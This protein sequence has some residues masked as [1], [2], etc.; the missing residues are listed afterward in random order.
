[1]SNPLK[2]KLVAFKINAFT[3]AILHTAAHAHI[4]PFVL[5]ALNVDD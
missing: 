3:A 2:N 4:G 1:M 5:K